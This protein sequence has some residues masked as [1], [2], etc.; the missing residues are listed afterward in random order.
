[1]TDQELKELV[2]SLALAQ[3]KTDEQ[4]AKTDAQLAKTDAQL[5]KTD[6]QLARS[7]ARLDKLA[8][9]YGGVA[10]NQGA[11]AEAFY[12][13]SLKHRPVLR[14]IRFDSVHKNLTSNSHGIE[15]EYDILLSNG[16]HVFI[17][18][19]KYK[20]HPH[21]VKTLIDKKAVNFKPLFPLY[22]DHKLHLGLASFYLD[23]ETIQ[24]ALNQGVTVLQRK[25]DLIETTPATPFH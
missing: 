5:A 24:S 17:I 15:D 11:V 6:A 16:Q 9:M 2:A 3:R 7:D 8:T 25:G 12:F 22:R 1:M 18:E 21:D 13:N 19:V 10:N 20:A 4:L 23:D 14:G